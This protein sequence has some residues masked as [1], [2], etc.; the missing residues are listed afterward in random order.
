[1]TEPKQQLLIPLPVK[2]EKTPKSKAKPDEGRRRARRKGSTS[3]RSA[4][5][6]RQTKKPPVGG[7]PAT[8]REGRPRVYLVDGPNIAYR[9]HY[10]IRGLVNRRGEATGATFGFV[11]MLFALLNDE[12][13]DAIAV[14]WDPRGGV[15]RNRMYAD[16]KGTRP[17]MPDEL[18]TQMPLF[19]QITKA[20]GFAWLCEDDYE[21][22]DVIGTLVHRLQ[23]T[24]DITIVTSD[25]DLMQLV[26]DPGVQV[27]DTM[28]N[29][30]ASEAQVRERW[31]VEPH[32]IVEMLALMGDSSDNIPGVAGIGQKGAAGLIADYG[33]VKS[34]FAHKEELK[35]RVKKPIQAEGAQESAE[36]S[37]ALATIKCDIPLD[38]ELA[39]LQFDFPPEDPEPLKALFQELEFHKFLGMVGGKMKTVD[40]SGYRC[41]TNSDELAE[42]EAAVR[43]AKVVAFDL[44]TSPHVATEAAILGFGVCTTADFAWYVPVGHTGEG[45]EA[46]L[47]LQTVLDRLGPALASRPVIGHDVKR[48]LVVLARHGVSLPRLAGDTM[49]AD[50]LINPSRRSH[51]LDGLAL[52]HL[53]HKMRPV[54]EITKAAGGDIAAVALEDATAFGAEDAHVVF[55]V[56]SRLRKA[57]D[58]AMLSPLY[59]DV[60]MPLV[61][62]LAQMEREGVKIDVAALNA[63]SD[64]LGTRAAEALERCHRLAE[65]H[66]NPNSTKQLARILFDV[67]GLPIIKRTRTGPSTDASVLEQLASEHELP[68]AVLAF[69]S[70]DKLKN[71]YV[72]ALP[73]Y[74]SRATGRIHTTFNQALAETG[75]LSSEDPN[76]QNIPI[77]TKEG[78]RIRATFVPEDGRVFVSCDYSQVELRVLAHLCGGEGGFARAFAA[79]KDV[80]RATAA[81]VFEVPEA[82]V[83]SEI[84]SAAKAINFGLV[85]GQGAW[86]L[87]QGL[88]ISKGEA[89]EYI[90]KYKA[91]YPEIEHYMSARIDEARQQ[92]YVT[93]I[94]GRRRRITDLT[95]SNY[96]QREASKRLAINTPVQGS[97]ADII[98]VAMIRVAK[99][100]ATEFPTARMLLQVHDELLFEVSPE[101]ADALADRVVGIMEGAVPLAI[102]LKVD[103]GRGSNWDEAH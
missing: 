83:T 55:L 50:Y 81:E 34:V 67:L 58:D 25:K 41:V 26:K 94:L 65:E 86:G 101:E 12:N 13:P 91:R 98:K 74:V 54:A 19:P 85:Y 79:G 92:G 82:E 36:L 99:M 66:F 39:D 18:K 60:E 49:I 43:E 46:Q 53:Q 22:D 3:A 6:Q 80:H 95:S 23:D 35:G 68:A 97:A 96:N 102:P 17:D 52:T 10:S 103:V 75:R 5:G 24:C 71:T 56:H 40:P 70:L 89:A 27:L 32:Q 64:E 31:G 38:I 15:F 63:L 11:N 73:N 76:V 42:L 51:A 14:V 47:A 69:R 61:P 59:D 44:V 77:R 16:Y 62:V 30:R 72:D 87:S 8:S 57:M 88:K 84:R 7:A 2:A 48:D 20:L 37:H 90:R 28:K 100:L 29:I 45:R 33:S 4:Q 93:T 1:M 78:R 21:A 9:A